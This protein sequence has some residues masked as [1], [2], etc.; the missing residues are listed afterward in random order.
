MDTRFIEASNGSNYGPGE[1][2]FS[3]APA[4]ASRP[5]ERSMRCT[6]RLRRHGERR[7]RLLGPSGLGARWDRATVFANERAARLAAVDLL[8]A[9]LSAFDSAQIL[10][11]AS[12][13]VLGRI[14][15]ERAP[16]AGATSGDEPRHEVGSE[17]GEGERTL[18]AIL[19]EIAVEALASGDN[20]VLTSWQKLQASR[21]L[22]MG[23]R[24]SASASQ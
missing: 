15:I 5:R 11:A 12:R 6:V 13:R 19:D 4:T 14:W 3:S 21:C 17:S 18:L 1:E 24:R 8:A 22:L 2:R 9:G 16:S 10:D 20:G 7:H 23:D